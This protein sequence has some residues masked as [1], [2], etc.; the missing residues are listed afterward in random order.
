MDTGLRYFPHNAVY[1]DHTQRAISP[2]PLSFSL[3]ARSSFLARQGIVAT[4]S[5]L[6]FLSAAPAAA[7][8]PVPRPCSHNPPAFTQKPSKGLSAAATPC[9]APSYLLTLPLWPYR[10]GQAQGG[11][12]GCCLP[13]T[14]SSPTG[15]LKSTFS[16]I[17]L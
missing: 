8:A 7:A 14:G 13:L 17:K 9:T 11:L 10:R 6:V 12:R 1:E 4:F 3:P 15:P 16:S 2:F 5:G